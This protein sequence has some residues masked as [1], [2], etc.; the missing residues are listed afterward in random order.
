MTLKQRKTLFLGLMTIAA[1][2]SL[3][4]YN[5]LE[6]GFM[7]KWIEILLIQQ[8]VGAA[9]YLAC[10]GTSQSRAPFE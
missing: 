4:F 9:L 7:M 8:L 3:V 10:F 2:S 6:G 5:N 1:G